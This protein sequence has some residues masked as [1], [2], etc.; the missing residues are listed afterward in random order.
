VFGP[1]L[2]TS[3]V[4]KLHSPLDQLKVWP[5]PA[6][7]FINVATTDVLL[8]GAVSIR[9]SDIQG[10]VVISDTYRERTDISSLAE[11]LYFITV[12]VNGRPVGYSR[13]IKSR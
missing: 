2:I 7:D 6:R 9:I 4:A 3:S 8:Q 13:F 5:N 10:R 12:L 1:P 11:G